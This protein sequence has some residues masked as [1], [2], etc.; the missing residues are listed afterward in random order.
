[1]KKILCPKCNSDEL[2]ATQILKLWFSVNREKEDQ[3]NS[4]T[5]KKTFHCYKCEYSFR[6]K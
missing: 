3:F 6:E 5:G 4:E 1:M 2:Y